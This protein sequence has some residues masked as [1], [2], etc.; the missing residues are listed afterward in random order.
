MQGGAMNH[1]DLADV[2]RTEPIALPG[3]QAANI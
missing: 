2:K 3:V 1:Q